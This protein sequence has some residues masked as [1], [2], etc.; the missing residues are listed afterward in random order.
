VRA[1]ESLSTVNDAI[2]ELTRHIHNSKHAAALLGISLRT[3]HNRISE[4]RESVLVKNQ[5]EAE[6]CKF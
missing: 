5:E 4:H 2:I 1:G 3:I 6:S